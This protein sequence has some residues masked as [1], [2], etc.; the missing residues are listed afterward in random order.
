M[1]HIKMKV[2]ASGPHGHHEAGK[3]YEVG[4]QIDEDLAQAFLDGGYAEE[5]TPT[6]KGKKEN[7]MATG[8]LEN[9]SANESK[10]TDGVV[11]LL[12][13]DQGKIKAGIKA[14]PPEDLA[15]T[16]GIEAQGK[17]RAW[18]LKLVEKET[19]ARKKQD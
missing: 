11:A 6:V 7:A 9:T 3:A 12:A 2:T 8:A 14:L 15:R 17:N 19:E 10:P 16:A 5:H 1:K 13:G 18:V 4:T